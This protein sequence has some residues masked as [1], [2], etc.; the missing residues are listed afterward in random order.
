M[1]DEGD[2]APGELL[3]QL[4]EELG[5]LVVVSAEAGEGP[6]LEP[7][8]KLREDFTIMEKAPT[9]AFPWLKALTSAF[10]F[11][12]LCEDGGPSPMPLLTVG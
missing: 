2:V 9:K 5:E 8:T 10:T 6:L 7:Q 4:G 3:H 11:K 12:K 1:V